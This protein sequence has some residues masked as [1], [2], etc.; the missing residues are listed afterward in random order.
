[1][2]HAWQQGLWNSLWLPSQVL[3][4]TKASPAIWDHRLRPRFIH[5]LMWVDLVMFGV[6]FNTLRPRQIGQQLSRDHFVY[7]PSQWE[8]MLHYN[9]VSHW[10]GAYAKWSSYQW[11][12]IAI[13]F[14]G[15]MFLYGVTFNTFWSP[16][17]GWQLSDNVWYPFFSIYHSLI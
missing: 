9:I 17:N 6:T 16:K 13:F 8:T 14:T 1:M 2:V 10:L 7:V 12:F 15:H 11:H 5:W 3:I 4:L